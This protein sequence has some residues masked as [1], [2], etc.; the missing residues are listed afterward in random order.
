VDL[1]AAS[2]EV[3]AEVVVALVGGV[4]GQV[5]DAVATEV[6][7]DPEGEDGQKEEEGQGCEGGEEDVEDS[8]HLGTM[9]PR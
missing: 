4:V 2:A 8:G 1:G 9:L 5:L 6:A 7:Q 3:D